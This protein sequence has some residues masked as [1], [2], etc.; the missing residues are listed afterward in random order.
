M[1]RLF[2]ELDH[3]HFRF[4]KQNRRKTGNP[5]AGGVDSISWMRRKSVVR[6]SIPRWLGGRKDRRRGMGHGRMQSVQQW[7]HERFLNETQTQRHGVDSASKRR[8]RRRR[9]APRGQRTWACRRHVAFQRR[10]DPGS[11]GKQNLLADLRRSREAR[12][13]AGRACR[14]PASHGFRWFRHLLSG[15]CPRSSLSIMI[16]AAAM[17]AHG[18]F[19]RFPATARGLSRRRRDLGAVYPGPPR[20]LL[21]SGHMQLDLQGKLLGGPKEEEKASDYF[22]RHLAREGYLLASIVTTTGLALRSKK[23]AGSPFF[24]PATFPTKSSMPRSAAMRSTSFWGAT[25]LA[26]RIRKP[27]WAAMRSGF[28]PWRRD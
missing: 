15:S 17:L 24:L 7:L 22:R 10:S 23:A 9:V 8:G 28:I 12:L 16:Q 11:P 2:P 1:A 3:F 21:S 14:L 27:H 19:E 4:L 25:I 6:C 20:P 26:R 13:R 18:V 5:R